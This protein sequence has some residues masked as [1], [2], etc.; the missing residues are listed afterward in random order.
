M[1]PLSLIW[2]SLLWIDGKICAMWCLAVLL[3]VSLLIYILK[4]LILASSS[5]KWGLNLRW[6]FERVRHQ[7]L[8]SVRQYFDLQHDREPISI[9]AAKL[10]YLVVMSML[11]FN[12]D[13]RRPASSNAFYSSAEVGDKVVYRDRCKELVNRLNSALI[14][15]Q[16]ISWEHPLVCCCFQFTSDFVPCGSKH[17]YNSQAFGCSCTQCLFPAFSLSCSRKVLQ[18]PFHPWR[19]SASPLLLFLPQ[20]WLCFCPRELAAPALPSPLHI[21]VTLCKPSCSYWPNLSHS[22]TKILLLKVLCWHHMVRTEKDVVVP[23]FIVKG[24]IGWWHVK[25]LISCKSPLVFWETLKSRE[26]YD[27]CNQEVNKVNVSF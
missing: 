3:A 13:T 24:Q 11:K 1:F 21:P 10:A 25:S 23:A 26:F 14:Q 6:I 27:P 20:S 5:T 22:L 7:C 9:F 15:C 16:A 19:A 18:S 17:W 2:K 4:W 8:T 12:L